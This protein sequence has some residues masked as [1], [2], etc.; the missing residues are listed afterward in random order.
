MGKSS[1][2]RIILGVDKNYV[3]EVFLEKNSN[4]YY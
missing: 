3:G 1:L 2:L 4:I